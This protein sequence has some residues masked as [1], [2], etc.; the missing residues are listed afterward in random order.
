MKRDIIY[1]RGAVLVLAAGLSSCETQE[2]VKPYALIAETSLTFE[3]QNAEPQ[4][5]T[6]ASDEGWMVDVDSDWIS[7]DHMSGE[8]TV[9]AQVSVLDNVDSQG[10]LAAPRSGKITIAT[11]RGNYSVETIIYQN[12][13]TYL[14]AAEYTVSELVA[15]VN[16]STETQIAAKVKESTVMAVA[17]EGFVI[18]DGT[19]NILVSGALDV[20]VGNKV[21]LNGYKAEANGVPVF[22]VD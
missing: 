1:S 5:L 11:T 10:K 17:D 20:A 18:S 21:T 9:Y 16:S 3:A 4:T 12:G 2:L 14:E 8:N 15:L 6:I 7:I 13:D 19:S 22:L